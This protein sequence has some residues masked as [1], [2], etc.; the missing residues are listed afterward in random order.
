MADPIWSDISSGVTTPKST[1]KQYNTS[2]GKDDFLKIL[3]TQLKNQ[4]PASPLQDKDFIAQ[5][6]QFTSVEQLTNI[7]TEMKLMRQSIGVVSSLIG[8]SV[9]WSST[10]QAGKVIIKTG[11]VDS[12]TM[13][14]GNQYA[15]VK[16]EA[17]SLDRITKIEN[18]N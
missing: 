6:A 3:I 10:D 18:A 11:V 17:V 14:D 13:K 7:S 5:M 1:T 8:K 4:D 16:G 15:D 2:L 9:T 12:I